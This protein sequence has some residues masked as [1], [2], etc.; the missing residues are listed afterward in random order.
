MEINSRGGRKR[1]PW[2]RRGSS[3][4]K[5]RKRQISSTLTILVQLLPL[6]GQ[7]GLI[8]HLIRQDRWDFITLLL[9]SV[10]STLALVVVTLRRAGTRSSQVLV[11]QPPSSSNQEQGNA[12]NEADMQELSSLE[13]EWLESILFTPLPGQEEPPPYWQSMVHT[14]TSTTANPPSCLAVIGRDQK[15]IFSIDLAREG[16]HALVAGTTGSGKSVF[17]QTW[18][19]SLAS[20][21][22]P[23]RLNLVLLDFKGGSGFNLLA[24]LPQTVGCVNDLDLEEA[25][26]ALSGIQR[27]LRRREILLASAG[28]SDTRDLPT[29]PPQLLI[30]IDEFQAL[31]HELPE[32]LDNLTRLASQGRSLGMNLVVCT[33]H[34]IGQVGSQMRANMNLNICLRVRDPLQSREL[35]GSDCAAKIAPS[36]PGLGF[37]ENGSGIHSFQ[38]SPVH[39]P[40]CLIDQIGKAASFCGFR[41]SPPLFSS[42]LPSGITGRKRNPGISLTKATLKEDHL[43]IPIGWMDDGVLLHI[44]RLPL[45]THTALIGPDGRGKSTL[46][47]SMATRLMALLT[48]ED[49][50]DQPGD[51]QHLRSARKTGYSAYFTA[52]YGEKYITQALQPVSGIDLAPGQVEMSQDK[53]LA[54]GR[55][56]IWLIDD[57]QDLLDP[58]NRAPLAQQTQQYLTKKGVVLVVAVNSIMDI[59]HPEHYSQRL[60][61]PFGERSLDL[62]CGIP[63]SALTGLG[64]SN[65]GIPGRCLLMSGGNPIPVQCF[66]PNFSKNHP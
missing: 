37:Y 1:K 58:L 21:L 15:G 14:W 4:P 33:Q 64:R 23:S 40:A 8:W 2:A 54:S 31:R 61:F 19:L 41:P 17:L 22:P 12:P 26:R 52:K 5:N 43:E 9:P 34:T 29:P 6:L 36:H 10:L 66:P 53:G 57:A 50:P 30:L 48:K 27:E 3:S 44:C 24:K 56:L 18:C 11:R 25:T 60:V 51:R 47:H 35:L 65:S 45:R 62:S 63:P 59:R 20:R 42:P 32:Y 28:V 49:S 7:L 38:T 55:R 39:D 46:L 16:P 13:P